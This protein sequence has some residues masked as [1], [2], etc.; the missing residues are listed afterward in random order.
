MKHHLL[1][2]I[3]LLSATIWVG[4]HLILCIRYLPQA[5]KKKDPSILREF[6]KQYEPIGI[7]ALLL[8]VITGILMAYDYNVSVSKWFAFSSSIEK[9]VSTKLLL[10]FL[11]LILAIHARLFIIP[12]LEV[13]TLRLMSVHIILL[14]IV[15]ILMLVFGSII[16]I[17]GI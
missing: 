8:L 3:H 11:T 14:T 1:L 7:P 9:V 13:S 10:L 15:S 12:K 16:R 2:I 6:E 4:G 17:G 5:L